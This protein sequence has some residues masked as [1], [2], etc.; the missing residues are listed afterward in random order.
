KKDG[1]SDS[2]GAL[3]SVVGSRVWRISGLGR[4]MR[5]R[6]ASAAPRVRRRRLLGLADDRN[7][8]KGITPTDAGAR[9]LAVDSDRPA[10]SAGTLPSGRKRSR[11]S[12]PDTADRHDCLVAIGVV[13]SVST[14][15]VKALAREP[16]CAAGSRL[17]QQRNVAV[18]GG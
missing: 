17:L 7:R 14:Q 5:S 16:P 13:Q 4:S 9:V 2:L 18:A 6:P 3:I 15:M 12:A 10:A 11:A 8:G 1:S